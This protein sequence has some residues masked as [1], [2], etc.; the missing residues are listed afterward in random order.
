MLIGGES[1]KVL[2]VITVQPGEL[3]RPRTLEDHPSGR[4]SPI[5]PL[6]VPRQDLPAS[7]AEDDPVILA[8]TPRR[9]RSDPG[10]PRKSPLGHL[11]MRDHHRRHLAINVKRHGSDPGSAKS[12]PLQKDAL[13]R[14]TVA[15]SSVAAE[16][17]I[18]V[19][20]S[21]D[22]KTS[23]GNHAESNH[24]VCMKK[25]KSKRRDPMRC[26]CGCCYVSQ[27]A[28]PCCPSLSWCCC[29]RPTE[30]QPIHEDAARCGCYKINCCGC[31]SGCMVT[32]PVCPWDEE[33][34]CFFGINLWYLLP[35]PF[36]R[37]SGGRRGTMYF[38]Q[39]TNEDQ[40]ARPGQSH[41]IFAEEGIE[42]KHEEVWC[43][44]TKEVEDFMPEICHCQSRC[45]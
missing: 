29:L 35:I 40:Y 4:L 39:F 9:R 43:T 27:Y 5:R 38:S 24:R 31:I 22:V 32:V 10:T 36:Y 19:E 13:K 41:Y 30:E 26:C 17:S 42:M 12:S 2:E 20:F 23:D 25:S 44:S 45:A 7:P 16:A 37:H 14:V 18:V 15:T 11:N 21:D 34:S 33:P 6:A 3:I 1:K 8:N 28:K